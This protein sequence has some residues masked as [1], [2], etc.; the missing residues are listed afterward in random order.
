MRGRVWLVVGLALAAAGILAGVVPTW[1]APSTPAVHLTRWSGGSDPGLH[2]MPFPGTPD[3]SPMSEVMFSALPRSELRS[4]T[5]V[6]SRSGRHVGRLLE[7]PDG[8]GTAF[9]PAHPF[10]TSEKVR[11]TALLRSAADG[12]GSGARGARRLS[13]SFGVEAALPDSAAPVVK[14]SAAHHPS[15]PGHAGAPG[16][17]AQS[18]QAAKYP[19]QQHFHSMPGLE[20]PVVHATDNSD[21]ASGDIFVTPGDGRQHGPMILSPQGRLVWFDHIT[22]RLA[23]YNL[24]VQKYRGKPMLTWW[25]GKFADAHG[26]DGRGV[27]MNDRYRIVKTVRAGNGYTSDLHEFQITPQGTA[28]LDCYVPVRANLTSQGGSANGIVLDGVIQKIDIRTGRVLWEWHSLGHVPIT[29]SE[30]GASNGG[31]YDYFHVN[32]I[33]EL[34]GGKVLIS[35]RNTWALYLI[36]ERTG[37]VDWT[38]GGKDSNFRIGLGAGFQWQHHAILHRHGL[39]SLFDDAEVPQRESSSSAKLLRINTRARTVSLVRRYLHRPPVTSGYMGSAQLLPNHNVFVGWGSTD[40]FSEYSP[41]GH[42]IFKGGV[43]GGANSYRAYRF[44]W[45]GQPGTPPSIAISPGS[46]GTLRVYSAW[47]GATDVVRW[48]ALGGPGRNRLSQV[49]EV[50]D[51]GFE[52]AQWGQGDPRYLAVE[53]LGADGNVL[54]RSATIVRPPR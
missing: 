26:I 6:G 45:H 49:G 14:T 5:V 3:A 51:R 9:V 48:R 36:D 53:A 43:S 42:Q 27:I 34:S 2:V 10:A 23:I 38:L 28:W 25:Q 17:K 37:R 15:A 52:T 29:A 16:P 22:N 11:V 54:G 4:V 35:A 33:Q 46:H 41:G 8:S 32:S 24:E 44:P 12:T 1:A 47:N 20:P 31:Q 18:A 30:I 13:F 50:A 39:L 7:L 40:G 21:K 19:P